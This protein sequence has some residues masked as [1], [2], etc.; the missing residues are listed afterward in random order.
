MS[1]HVRLLLADDHPVF[2][3]GLRAALETEPDL[4]VVGVAADGEEAIARTCELVPDVVV[5][6]LHMPGLGGIEATRRLAEVAPAVRVLVLTML[7]EDESVFAA[8]RVGA[9]GYVLK[10][11][12]RSEIVRAIRAVGQG[13]M[14]FGPAVARRMLSFFAAAGDPPVPF[15]ELTARE[16]EIL[17]LLAAGWSNDRIAARLFLSA[18]TVRNNVSAIFRKLGVRDRPEAIVRAREA[19][20][21]GGP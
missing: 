17:E 21:G 8:M 4:K 15:P 11:A 12:R 18:K 16:R 14:I 20:L 7:E 6:D 13:E 1:Q 5:M 9:L 19:G 3:D 10:G 2:A